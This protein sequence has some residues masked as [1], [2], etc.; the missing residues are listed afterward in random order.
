MTNKKICGVLGIL[1][2]F[3]FLWLGLG[4]FGGVLG[5]FMDCHAIFVK[6]A[7]NDE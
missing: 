5:W 1:G 7:R 6:T 2:N 3:C 4:I